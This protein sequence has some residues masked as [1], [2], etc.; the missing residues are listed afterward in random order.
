MRERSF[1]TFSTIGDFKCDCSDDSRIFVLWIDLSVLLML[2]NNG[3]LKRYILPSLFVQNDVLA[4]CQ[5]F[6]GYTAASSPHHVW[7]VSMGIKHLQTH[8]HAIKYELSDLFVFEFHIVA[9]S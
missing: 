4:Q 8:T 7:A 5:I 1:R 2:S 6:E 9:C 3:R